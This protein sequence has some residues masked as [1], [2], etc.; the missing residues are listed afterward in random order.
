MFDSSDFPCNELLGTLHAREGVTKKINKD[1]TEVLLIISLDAQANYSM[2]I[3]I[4]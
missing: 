4:G 2:I 3:K 1:K